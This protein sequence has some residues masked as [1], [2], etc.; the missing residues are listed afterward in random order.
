MPF[1]AVFVVLAG[2]NL[3]IA[4]RLA[5]TAFPA[6]VHPYV[7]RFHEVFGHR[8]RLVRYVGAGG[9][10][11]CSS[12]LPTTSHWQDWLLFRNSTS[13]GVEDAQFGADVGFYVFEL[14]FISFV[15]DWL[16]AA[17]V[18]VLLLT[19][20]A[21]LLNGGVLFASPMPTVRPATKAHLAVLLAVLAALKAADYWLTRYE[22]DERASRLRAGRDLRRRQRAAPGA[23]AADPHRPA[24]RRRCSCRRSAPI[25]VAP[26]AGRVGLWL[27][28]LL[29]GGLDLPGARAVARRQPQPADREAPYIDRNVDR[30]PRRRWASS[31]VDVEQ[32]TF[33][34]LT[35]ERG[36]GRP[37]AAARRAAAQP[38]RDA[39]AV[40]RRRGGR[41][42]S[43]STISTSTA[44]CSTGEREQVLIAARELD[45]DGSAN[46]SWQ[47]RHLINTRGCG[48]V[49]APAS[50]VQQSDRPDYQNVEL[51]RPELYFSP[52]LTGYAIARTTRASGPCAATTAV[53][54]G[55]AGVQMSS[56]AR[57]A[58]FALAFL[59]YNVVGSGADQRRLADAV[60][61]RRARPG[62]EA[63]AV[64][65]VRR[66]PV[67]GRRR[68]PG[69]RGWS[70]ATRRRAA[71]R[72]PSASATTSQLTDDTGLAARRP[73]TSATA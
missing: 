17:M 20:L 53:L 2:L 29:I 7:E 36:R 61:A 70:T 65:V 55:T 48:L 43:R 16:F 66:R 62:G 69:A 15:L 14:P 56:F 27:V 6:N 11:R 41:P 58:A 60:G 5:P 68:R 63:G 38:D 59:D 73:T 31:D 28:V 4:D 1:F 32:V 9:A 64:P 25:V 23:D 30:H 50:R 12:P 34:T 35:A 54:R 71:T 44:T 52:S 13:F 21:H 46:Q 24:H 51:T 3:L 40:P 10:R 26:A 39:V 67:P 72:T 45:L 49:M 8:L 37:R 47:G 19:L 57:R 22:T 33:G 42:G 18:V